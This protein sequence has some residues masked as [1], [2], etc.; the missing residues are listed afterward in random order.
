MNPQNQ[1]ELLTNLGLTVNQAKIYLSCI[2]YNSST[3]KQISQTTNLASEIVYRTI[4]KL[5]KKGLVTKT[6]A[7]PAEY[8][9]TPIELAI[10]T[11]LEQRKKQNV[12]LEKKAKELLRDMAKRKTEKHTESIKIVLIPEKER[13]T[14]FTEKKMRT[15]KK[16]L[17]VIGMGQKFHAWMRAYHELI[18][19]LLTK[20]IV[21]KIVFAGTQKNNTQT[22]ED[23]LEYSD[24]IIRFIPDTVQTCLVIVDDK[25]VI[26]DTSPESGFAQTPVYWSNDLGIVAPCKAYFEK[27]WNQKRRPVS[28]S[29]GVNAF[30]NKN[31]LD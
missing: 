24:F 6:L 9:A 2:N 15:T 27:Y 1:I 17:Q 4:P 12:E 16:S 3:V 7:F 26:I 20:N 30:S 21:V 11:L 18:D 8:Q 10:T 25:E 14:Q 19:D 22:V 5:Q 28:A 31:K 13:Q 29:E 23:I